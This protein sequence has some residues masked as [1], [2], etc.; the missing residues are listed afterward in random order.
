MKK[1]IIKVM[2][3]SA[4]IAVTAISFGQTSKTRPAPAS[5]FESDF[6]V[7]QNQVLKPGSY[8]KSASFLSSMQTGADRLVNLQNNDGG[9]DW[10]LDDGNPANTSP[11]N[12][13]GPIAMG[14]AQAYLFTNDA[15]HLAALSNAGGLLLTKTNNFSP[16]D[17]YLAKILDQIFGVTTYSSHVVANFYG[18]LAAGNYDINGAS[19]L[20]STAQYVDLIRTSRASQGIPNLAAWDVGMGL[21][22]AASCGAS[23]SEWIAGV[24][25]EI[26]ELDGA[27]YY[28]VIGL[29]GAVYGLAFVGEDYTPIAGQHLGAADIFALADILISYQID[30]GGF[31]WNSGFVIPN[32]DN[33]TVQETAYAML[34]LVELDNAAYR[35]EILGAFHYLESIQLSTG[36]WESY[37][38]SGENN[39][40]TA[41]AMWANAIVMANGP[42]ITIEPP[43]AA[44]CTEYSFEVTVADF[45]L[46][47]AISMTLEFDDG[48]LG[49]PTVVLNPAIAGSLTGFG[50]DIFY[51][52]QD[53]TPAITLPDDAVL[54][55]LNFDILQWGVPTT[56]HWPMLPPEANELAGPNGDPVYI[57]SFFDITYVIPDE[58]GATATSTP[59]DCPFSNTGSIDL[60]PTGGVLPYT[61]AWTGP[62]GFTSNV[63]DPGGL[64]TGTYVV[65]IT[66]ANGCTK[67]LS[68]FVDFIDDT[69]PPDITCA[70][71]ASSYDAD[72]GVCDYTVSGTPPGF[73]TPKIDY[74]WMAMDAPGNLIDVL[75]GGI[76]DNPL[77][78]EDGTWYEYDLAPE[79]WWNIWFYNDP[80][81]LDRMKIV[82]M[83]FWIQTLDVINPGELFY[84]VNWSNELYPNASGTFPTSLQENFIERSPINFVDVLPG[85]AQ[86]IELYWVIPDYNPEWISV[87]IWGENIIIEEFPLSPP[88]GSPLVPYWDPLLPGGIIVHECLPKLGTFL[89]PTYIYDYCGIAS[90]INDHTLTN[91]LAGATFPVGTTIVTWTATDLSG[92]QNTCQQTIN[93]VDNQVPIITGCPANITVNTGPGSIS[94]DQVAT[95][96]EPIASDNCGIQSFT[97]NYTSGATFPVG[98]TTV[99]YTATDY[100]TPPNMTICSFTVTVVDNTV[101]TITCAVPANPYYVNTACTYVVPGIGLNPTATGDNC[102]V[103]S[104]INDF[105]SSNTLAGAAF[106]VGNTTVIWTITDAANPPNTATCS[107]IVTVNR[108]G[109][110]GNLTYH[111][112]GQTLGN[113]VITLDDGVNPVLT[114][115]TVPGTGAYGFSNLCAGTYDLSANFGTKAVG[116]INATDAAQTN[117]WGVAPWPIEKVRFYAGDASLTNYLDALDAQQI[118]SYFVTAGGSAITPPWKF[119]VAGETINANP[120]SPP[121]GLQIP[122]ITIGGGDATIN[123]LG[124]VTGDFNMSY[125]LA[126]KSGSE[127]LTLN[128]GKNILAEV[129]SELELPIVAGMD[130]DLGAVSLILNFPADKLEI[131]EIFLT[132]NPTSP[133]MYNIKGDELR[134]GWNSLVPVYLNEGESL[135]TLKMKVIAEA[136]LEG[137]SLS[138]VADPLNELA[139][140]NFLVINDA[141]LEVDVIHTSALGMIQN[142]QSDKLELA[143]HPNPFN[144]TTN[145]VY[146]L[147]VDGK[148][149]L[150]IYDLLGNKVKVAVEENQTAG[151]YILKLNASSF[152]PGVYTATLK[153]NNES[154]FITRT[155]KIISK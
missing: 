95:W 132:S 35:T 72:P 96:T 66:D 6:L 28:D 102:L 14:L 34:A 106:P 56:L 90:V 7:Q 120:G 98:T 151:E 87:D 41:E 94:C 44:N 58:L 108:I 49:N 152:Q 138:L 75:S 22:G 48:V 130:M 16:S 103:L 78:G 13:V 122:S 65:L 139:D 133:L 50:T 51:L 19:V 131:N 25:G 27:N 63:Q 127:T 46:V 124:Q 142:N 70:I 39:E 146:S 77:E 92:N 20:Y 107:Y 154:T 105:N 55:T 135:I 10:P 115:T 82:H 37:A 69:T 74:F 84:V 147:P 118:L 83:G 2:F 36:G 128:T 29:A 38:G 54:L 1:L 42:S 81:D 110:S 4:L 45:N 126:S 134:I 5:D 140:G 137:M 67:T 86:W 30:L 23:T 9:W 32:N 113:V 17:G 21:I 149:I 121:S 99:A 100:A 123:L 150:E 68:V 24:K 112:G 101:P 61:Y 104:V 97:S 43:T 116:G 114:S 148:V 11:L 33:E 109:I 153:L 57:D 26:D 59:T 15:A 141:V 89:D 12:T 60:T 40:I 93:V 80:F 155:I 52:A 117:Y 144:G 18:P 125:S 47:G 71:P 129:G 73:S 85:P 31:T 143:N 145:F 53:Y 111:N 62:S 136:G 64:Y 91:T 76:V 79:P 88:A 8:L 119:W 3:V